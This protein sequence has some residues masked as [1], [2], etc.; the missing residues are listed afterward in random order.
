MIIQGYISNMNVNVNVNSNSN[1]N[2]NGKF[3]TDLYKNSNDD[4]LAWEALQY[5]MVTFKKIMEI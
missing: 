4:Q 3:Y 1:S 2:S 5:L